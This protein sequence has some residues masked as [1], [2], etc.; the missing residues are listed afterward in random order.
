MMDVYRL[1]AEDDKH[2][3]H[4][5]DFLFW[6][7]DKWLPAVAGDA[8]YGKL[9]RLNNMLVD[10]V[11][12]CGKDRVVVSTQSE[13][14]GWLLLDNCYEKWVAQ[15]PHL[16]LDNKWRPPKYNKDDAKTHPYHPKM[17]YTNPFGGRGVGWKPAAKSA[18]DQYKALVTNFRADDAKKG[19]AINKFCLELLRKRNNVTDTNPVGKTSGANKRKRNGSEPVYE[20]KAEDFK[21]HK[22]EESDGEYTVGSETSSGE[23]VPTGEAME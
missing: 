9:I 7:L 4:K 17:K 2:Y 16:K 21:E 18:L 5:E 14:F 12:K 11:S 15:M 1:P 19:W 23:N 3:E 6:Y 8:H 20:S 13:A 10:K 22:Q